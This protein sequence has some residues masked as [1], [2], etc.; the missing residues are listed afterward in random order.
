MEMSTSRSAV[1]LVACVLIICFG[2]QGTR[3]LAAPTSD[4]S[5][6]NRIL[7]SAPLGIA[8]P[9]NGE[10]FVVGADYGRPEEQ[11]AA[12]R[13]PVVADDNGSSSDDDDNINS[14]RWL[15]KRLRLEG[16]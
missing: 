16:E 3:C 14:E 10:P 2:R 13:A 1:W 9:P 11:T 15:S 4:A 8:F 7:G 5:N 12:L 6:S